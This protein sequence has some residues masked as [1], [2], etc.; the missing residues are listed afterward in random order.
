MD[1][2]DVQLCLLLIS[3][4][5]RTFRELGAQVNLSVN[6]VHRRIQSLVEAGIIRKFSA[7]QSIYVIRGL[8]VLVFG[9]GP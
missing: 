9:K 2:V 5:R 3:N 6:A 4:S 8:L 7:H 1:E